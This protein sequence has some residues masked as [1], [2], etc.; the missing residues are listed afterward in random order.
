MTYNYS[1]KSKSE[2]YQH[3]VAE[4]LETFLKETFSIYFMLSLDKPNLPWMPIIRIILFALYASTFI[5]LF[6]YA[7]FLTVNIFWYKIII[8]TYIGIIFYTTFNQ[9]QLSNL[10]TFFF[11]MLF[12]VAYDFIGFVLIGVLWDVNIERD[13][14]WRCWGRI[15]WIRE[16]SKLYILER[17]V[18]SCNYLLDT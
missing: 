4:K 2:V 17:K 14:W 16:I 11:L 18:D 3:Q 10:T 12:S 1:N 7:D 15:A 5:T 6:A 8:L 9:N 13:I